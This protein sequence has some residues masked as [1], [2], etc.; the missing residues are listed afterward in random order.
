MP[1]TRD[2]SNTRPLGSER[3]LTA[4]DEIRALRLDVD[5]RLSEIIGGITT[6]VGR[7][8]IVTASALSLSS[9]VTS[10]A[11]KASINTT[12]NTIPKR[13]GT[14]TLADSSIVDTG[15][16]VT[17]ASA[18]TIDSLTVT[19]AST[20]TGLS[21]LG[22]LASATM[23][24]CSLQQTTNDTI[25][26]GAG[27]LFNVENIDVGAMHSASSSRI[28][29]PTG[30]GGLYLI[31]GNVSTSHTWAFGKNG[32]E[33]YSFSTRFTIG[34]AVTLAVLAA[35]DYIEL[36]NV[37]AGTSGSTSNSGFGCV[38]LW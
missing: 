12:T 15:S 27:I 7:D 22:L 30:G 4:D 11:T 34:H 6:L 20:H 17:I 10:L 19:G 24:R 36:L 26:S 14:G 21:T 29:V 8:P 28:T 3:A 31:H 18:T 1:F 23:Q 37:N 9:I 16:L 35:A 25:L 32:T 5:Q 38:R 2:W 13:S 33:L